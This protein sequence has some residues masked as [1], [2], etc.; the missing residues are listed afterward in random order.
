MVGG[1]ALLECLRNSRVE[2]VLAVGRSLTGQTHP[3]LR[4]LI[5]ADFFNY[6]NLRS[7]F[8]IC[9]ACFFCLGV[10]ELLG[11]FPSIRPPLQISAGPLLRSPTEA[12]PRRFCILATSTPWQ[13][14]LEVYPTTAL[15]QV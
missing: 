9:D 14:P 1:G 5:Q 2:S 15:S 12:I 4:Q 10:R 6:D 11:S 8:A 7:D 13:E 3:K